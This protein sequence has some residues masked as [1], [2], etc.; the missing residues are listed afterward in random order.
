MLKIKEGVKLKGIQ[1]EMVLAAQI[2]ASV[3]ATFDNAACVITSAKD[4]KHMD[5]SLHCVGY[6]LDFRTSHIRSGWQQ[7]LFDDVT[8]ALGAEYDVVPEPTHLHVEYDPTSK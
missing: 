2:V 3:Y 1:P 8:R 5:G 7:K 4:G 6:A